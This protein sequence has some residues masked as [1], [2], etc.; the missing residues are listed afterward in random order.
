MAAP[1]HAAG[2]IGTPYPEEPPTAASQRTD[3]SGEMVRLVGIEPTTSGAT[4]LRSNQL[5]YNRTRRFQRRWWVTYG[6]PRVLSSLFCAE[7]KRKWPGDRPAIFVSVNL[8]RGA[9]QTDL[10]DFMAFS[11]ADLP[12]AATFSA[13]FLEVS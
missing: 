2:R 13:T 12:G 10:K 8:A 5:S 11:A 4:N 6:Q 7:P 3:I 9:D 1:P